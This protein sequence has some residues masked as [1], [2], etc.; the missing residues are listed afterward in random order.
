MKI[1]LRKLFAHDITHEVSVTETIISEFFDNQRDNMIFVH[2]GREN[3]TEYKVCINKSKDARFGGDFKAIYREDNV[4]EGDILAIKK[5]PDGRYSLSVIFENSPL[6]EQTDL[7][8]DGK[9][10]HAIT[11]VIILKR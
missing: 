10:R 6:H 9:E 2:E 3:G 8:F 1:Y 11:D 5:L 4:K 7:I